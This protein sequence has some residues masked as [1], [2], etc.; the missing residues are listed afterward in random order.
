[1]TIKNSKNLT[2]PVYI[3]ESRRKLSILEMQRLTED[4]YRRS[5][6]RNVVLVLD[7][8]RSMHNVGAAFR[9]SDA[10][11]IQAIYLC[12]ITATPPHPLIRKTALG[13]EEAVEWHYFSETTEA[14]EAL[15]QQGYTLCVLE[16]TTK[17]CPLN[18]LP[19]PLLS[20]PVALVVGNEVYG[21][22]EEVVAQAQYALEIPQY[23]TKHS[24]N[25]SVATG[26]AL[27][28]LTAHRELSQ[29]NPV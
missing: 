3:M 26:I 1:M 18:Q 6:K 19:S 25:V 4:E 27:Y 10:F 24:L 2:Y 15:K 23:G 5:P 21:V 11:R 28:A 7:N 8:I 17:S 20:D 13:A 29:R 14:I 22:Q 9:S 16:Q 12:G